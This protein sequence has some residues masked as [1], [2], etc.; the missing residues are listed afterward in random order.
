[1]NKNL[2]V[3]NV[4]ILFEL[5]FNVSGVNIGDLPNRFIR[6]NGSVTT[7]ITFWAND[8]IQVNFNGQPDSTLVNTFAA[9]MDL[10][11]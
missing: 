3:Q 5:G 6:V 9:V 2:T 10:I 7:R 11:S 4:G 1:M 8:I